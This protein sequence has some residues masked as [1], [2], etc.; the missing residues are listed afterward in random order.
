[1]LTSKS[2]RRRSL[3]GG[4]DSAR[5]AVN[6]I[7]FAVL[8]LGA[9][10]VV[11][12]IGY[13][14]LGFTPLE[15]MYQTVTTVAT[16]GFREVRPLTTA[17]QVFT[18]VLILLGVGVV[19]YNLGVIVEA[20]TEG[21]LR[22]HLERRHMDRSIAALRG[23]IIICGYGRVGRAAAAQLIATGN[24]VV[25][26]DSD[27]SRLVG[28]TT[29]HLQGNA[30]DD[31]TLRAA[32]IA[33]ARALIVALDTDTDTVYVTLSARALRPDLVI[34]SRART[35]DAKE[36]MVL[37]G[38]TRA[39]NPQLIGGRRMAS[40]ALHRDVAEFLDVVMHDED[41]DYRIDQIRI[42]EGSSVS[43]R[44]IGELDLFQ[45]SGAQVLGLRLPDRGRFV[46]NPP[47][48]TVLSAGMTVIALGDSAQISTLSG[49][50]GS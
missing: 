6:R 3:L 16:V 43:G 25:V 48:D 24:D 41:I 8:A 45:R 13:V 37:A 34:I 47:P 42:P 28:L 5:S 26:I 17:G 10:M 1:M 21:H 29:P 40:F 38:A 33:Q 49:F 12:A 14:V 4:V 30:L 22:A 19:L 44:A 20:L 46:A 9:V 36:K 11:G 31:A 27:E 15:A 18:M 7:G 23:H 39:V 32:G 2:N 35:V 50:L